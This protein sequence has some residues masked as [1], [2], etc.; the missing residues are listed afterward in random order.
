VLP[1]G[2][3]VELPGRGTTFVREITGPPGAPAVLLLHGL[4]LTADVNW[5]ASMVPLGRHFRVIAFDQRGH[6]RG[7]RVRSSSPLEAWA[8][9]AAA[10][11]DALGIDRVIVAG[12]SMGGV[13]AQLVWRR[14]PEIVDGLVLCATGGD[15]RRP[16]AEQF[17]FYAM[18]RATSVYQSLSGTTFGQEMVGQWLLGAIRDPS[19]RAWVVS[20]VRKTDLAM[21]TAAGL[22]VSQFCSEEWVRHVSVPV[23]VVVTTADRVVPVTRQLE[24]ARAIPGAAAHVVA[25][26]HAAFLNQPELFV[27]A[28]VEACKVVGGEQRIPRQPAL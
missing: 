18:C 17:M 11:T 10:L 21:V 26:D 7:P 25:G 9:D 4:C 3:T 5:S 20:E 6:G 1:E 2:R 23:G 16:L 22:A 15:F 28:L 19:L 24:L 14:H 13:V 12:Y 27:P 8:D